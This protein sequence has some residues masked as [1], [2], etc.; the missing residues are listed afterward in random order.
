MLLVTKIKANTVIFTEGDID[1]TM[2][3]ILDGSVKTYVTRN[4]KDVELALLHEHDFFGEIEMYGNKPRSMSA[5]AVTDARLVVIKNRM[6]LDQ[7]FGQY[8]A[9]SGKILRIMGERLALV[10]AAL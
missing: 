2:F 4:G 5:Q 9:F 3:I 1:K 7:F 10:N 8:P 6:Q